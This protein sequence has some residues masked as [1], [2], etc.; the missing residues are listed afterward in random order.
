MIDDNYSVYMHINKINQK[1]YIGITKN[2]PEE[3]WL[4]GYGYKKQA[5]Y[6]AIQ[7]YGWDNFEHVILFDGLSQS[8]ACQKEIDLISYYKTNNKL[9]GYNIS[10]GGENGHNELWKDATYRESQIKKESLYGTMWSL[11]K[12]MPKR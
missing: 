3:R 11:E 1:K 10:S 5:F 8:E 2:K 6:N 12:I 7:K 4:N 9:Y